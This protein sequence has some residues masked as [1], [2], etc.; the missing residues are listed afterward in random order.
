[1][2]KFHPLRPSQAIAGCIGFLPLSR[3]PRA[4]PSERSATFALITIF[5]D[6]TENATAQIERKIIHLKDEAIRNSCE[7]GFRRMIAKRP[8]P[9]EDIASPE[10]R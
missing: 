5:C 2:V 6:I 8:S 7:L 10:V 3:A 4:Q 9:Q 1:M